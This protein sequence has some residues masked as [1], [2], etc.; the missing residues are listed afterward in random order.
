MTQLR[1]SPNDGAAND[2]FAA[3]EPDGHALTESA[4][5]TPYQLLINDGLPAWLGGTAA[6]IVVGAPLTSV[7]AVGVLSG[8]VFVGL[9]SRAQT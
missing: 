4:K 1:H 6:M 3:Q 8:L 7:L 9:R 2:G 5:Q